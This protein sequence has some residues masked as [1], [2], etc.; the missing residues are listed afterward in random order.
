MV[1]VEMQNVTFVQS[2]F[3]FLLALSFQARR[4]YSAAA[5]MC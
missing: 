4:S 2:L 1:I 3:T 5:F